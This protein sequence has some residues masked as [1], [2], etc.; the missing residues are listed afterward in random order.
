VPTEAGRRF[1]EEL[2]A[3]KARLLALRKARSERAAENAASKGVPPPEEDLTVVEPNIDIPEVMANICIEEQA[4]IALR[5]NR[6]RNPSNPDYDMS[7]PPTTYEEAMQH[8]DSAHWLAAMKAELHTM[9]DMGVYKLTKLPEG[10]KVIGNRWVL[11]FKEDNKGGPIHKAR[12]VAQGFSQVPGVDFSTTFAP[13][14]KTA[15]V[16]FIAALVCRNDWE[17]DTFD[18]QRAFLWGVLK[19]E[20]YMCQP[21]GFEDGDW[22]MMVWLMLRTIYGL[23]QSAMEWYKQV[24]AIM[25]ELGFTRCAVDYAVFVYDKTMPSTGHIYCIVGWHVNDGMGTSNSK[26]FLQY[27]KG[28][29]AQ[30]FGIK[31]LGPIQKF[32]GVQFEC[33]RATHELWMH[34]GEY[35]T[36]LLDDYDLLEC[37]P[38]HLPLDSNHP[39]GHPTDTFDDIPNLPTRYRK[40]I[41]E[42]L[43]LAVCTR[44]DIAFAV[45]ALAQHCANPSPH[46]YAAAKRL[47][48]YLSGTLNLHSHLGGDRA[49]EGLHGEGSSTQLRVQ[50]I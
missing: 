3:S 46:F 24:Q 14:I 43:Y 23:K 30:R 6:R 2:A 17:L 13:V 8:S 39:F 22:A 16:R 18:T 42:L 49:D 9:K 27:V 41:G 35:I 50:L 48:C 34:Q 10:R 40:I 19:E 4:H 36:H 45:N 1:A 15:S 26:P 7:L 20:I 28:R 32:L 31:D 11:E 33:N 29:I 25:I 38:V 47:L 44:A 21:K 37:N 12:L 5:S